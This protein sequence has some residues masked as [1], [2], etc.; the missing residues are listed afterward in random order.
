MFRLLR[1]IRRDALTAAFLI[2][3][4]FLSSAVAFAQTDTPPPPTAVPPTATVGLQFDQGI[5]NQ[6]FEQSN[7]WLETFGPIIAIGI[8][9]GIAVAILTFIG[10]QILDAF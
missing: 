5:T 9:I 8:G 3:S 1:Y 6:F 7:F 4:V 2:L 10:K